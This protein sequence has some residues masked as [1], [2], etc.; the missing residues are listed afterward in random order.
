M[1]VV[2]VGTAYDNAEDV[3]GVGMFGRI[4]GAEVGEGLEDG[5]PIAV[6]FGLE[7]GPGDR[8]AA[9]HLGYYLWVILLMPILDL[10]QKSPFPL[11][12]PFPKI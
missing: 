8:V 11:P 6:V 5:V 12:A 9:V 7:V 2:V 1:D 10:M 4:D 3:V